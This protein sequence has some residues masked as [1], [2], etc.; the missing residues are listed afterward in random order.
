MTT[1]ETL[2]PCLNLMTKTYRYEF[3]IRSP[4]DVAFALKVDL[5]RLEARYRDTYPVSVESVSLRSSTLVVEALVEAAKNAFATLDNIMLHATAP[6][7][8]TTGDIEGRTKILK[9]LHAALE[10]FDGEFQSET[11]E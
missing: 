2:E 9:G 11:V 8:M 1:K 10:P 6:G 5:E 3:T 7:G 4:E